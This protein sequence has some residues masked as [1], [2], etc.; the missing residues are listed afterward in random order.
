MKLS[1]SQTKNITNLQKHGIALEA[2]RLLDWDLLIVAEDERH[3][4]GEM[5]LIGFAPIA[6][7]LYCIVYT[8]RNE[9][10]HVISLRKANTR[11]VKR[12][13]ETRKNIKSE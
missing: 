8:E 3:D 1:Y 4:Y 10:I 6:K 9:N 5:R 11:E 2:A 13:V 12:Y 7:R